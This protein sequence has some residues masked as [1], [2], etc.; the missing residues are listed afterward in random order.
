MRAFLR[1]LE[2]D[3]ERWFM[4]SFY[5]YIVAVIFIEV[6]RRFVLSYS[7]VWGEEAARYAFVYLVWFGAAAAIK[8]RAHIRI[9]VIFEFVPKAITPYLYL[10]GELATLM[11]ALVALYYSTESVF[12]SIRFDSL[13]S[14]LRINQAWFTAAV[15]IGFTLIII[16]LLQ[17]ISRDISDIRAGRDVFTGK[18]MF[19]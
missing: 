10:F 4:L 7:S 6:I 13:T 9:D 12:S 11:F 17:R 14:G 1:K 18:K 19:S 3:F 2:D 8:E 5:S 15:P 16:R